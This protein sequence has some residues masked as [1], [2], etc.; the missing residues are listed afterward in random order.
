MDTRGA[1]IYQDSTKASAPTFTRRPRAEA[2]STS[3]FP[4]AS[5]DIPLVFD[6]AN[7]IWTDETDG[8]CPSGDPSHLT[9]RGQYPLPQPPQTPIPSLSGHGT[10]VQ[11][12]SCA[13][14][15]EFDET[16]TRT[17]D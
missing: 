9:A 10:S 11:T 1:A 17:G 16:V 15:F 13:V 3:Y 14:D 4:A 8:P 7:W 6:G 5:G 2:S 12:G